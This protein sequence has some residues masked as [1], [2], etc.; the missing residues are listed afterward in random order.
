MTIHS[1]YSSPH[2]VGRSGK[3]APQP[4]RRKP[5]YVVMQEGERFAVWFQEKSYR[6]FGSRFSAQIFA[7]GCNEHLKVAGDWADQSD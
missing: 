2:N 7:D 4:D 5:R 1:P 6:S 3:Q